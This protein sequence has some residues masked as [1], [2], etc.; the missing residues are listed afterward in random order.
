MRL[1]LVRHG[2]TEWNQASRYQGHQDVPLSDLGRV[3]AA[4]LRA[5]LGGEEI[6]AAYSSDLSRA[7][8]T[9][10]IALAG[11]A[12]PLQVTPALREISF[13]AWEGLCH[14]E[15]V[16]RYP[17]DWER[18]IRDPAQTKPTGGGESLTQLRDRV[19]AFYESAFADKGGNGE[20]GS[21]DW[22]T[23]R[24]AGQAIETQETVLVVSHGG[25]TRVLLTA[26]FGMP[27]AFY[28]RFAMRP[29]SVTVLDVYP[30]GPIAEVIG[31]TSHLVSSGPSTAP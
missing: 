18:W 13:A 2:L 15:I 12:V 19:L 5:R 25:S 23:Y 22:F 24:A 7:R 26:L 29:A 17:D 1:I 28:W 31:D 8:E 4:R 20:T 6:T 30:A 3:Q 9:A 10:E 14:E 11:R 21:T 16:E 27:V